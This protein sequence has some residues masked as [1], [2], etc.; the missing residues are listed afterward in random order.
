MGV[1]G[2]MGVMGDWGWCVMGVMG[3]WGWCVM[4]VMG[5]MGVTGVGVCVQVNAGECTSWKISLFM[6]NQEDNPEVLKGVSPSHLSPLSVSTSLLNF[7]SNSWYVYL[8]NIR[9]F[10]SQDF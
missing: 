4:G 9:F 2:V 10:N 6:D 1:M 3:D 8:Q 5:V 7:E